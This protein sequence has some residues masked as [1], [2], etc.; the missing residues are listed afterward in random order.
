[1][2]DDPYRNA[3]TDNREAHETTVASCEGDRCVV[4]VCMLASCIAPAQCPQEK[5]C[6]ARRIY[7]TG[8]IS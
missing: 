2:G 5:A 4:K 6:M 8:V 7:T 1:M 3:L